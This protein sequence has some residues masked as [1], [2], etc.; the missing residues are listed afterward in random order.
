MNDETPLPASDEAMPA[1]EQPPVTAAPAPRGSVAVERSRD[2]LERFGDIQREMERLW[3]TVSVRLRRGEHGQSGDTTWAPSMDVFEQDGQLVIRADLP[4]LAKDD[5]DVAL[6]D[7]N[8]VIRGERRAHSETAGASFYRAE[9]SY[10]SFYRSYPLDFDVDPD[11]IQATF[12]GG[13]LEVRVPKPDLPK[14][15]PRKIAIS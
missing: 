14:P 13:V 11:A 15:E 9:I 8:L 5:V 7:G 4:G 3:D 1:V 12:Q 2:P 10:G 6:E